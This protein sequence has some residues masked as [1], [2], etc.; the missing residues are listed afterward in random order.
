MKKTIVFIFL[1]FLTY[2][3][4]CQT[5]EN[6]SISSKKIV[7]IAN[8]YYI[9]TTITTKNYFEV[10]TDFVLNI[11][12]D[13]DESKREDE[14]LKKKQAEILAKKNER[15]ERNKL[16]KQAYKQG[17]KP[18]VK[19]LEDQGKIKKINSNLSIK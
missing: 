18:E 10:T 17:F 3:S 1:S 13:D 4:F 9:E 7:K 2:Q 19:T 6:S 5:P 15:Q 11:D 8:K 12:Q 16:I 14:E